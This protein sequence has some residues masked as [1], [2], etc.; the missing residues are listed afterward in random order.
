MPLAHYMI[1]KNIPRHMV[2]RAATSSMTL[3]PQQN[4]ADADGTLVV[5]GFAPPVGAFLQLKDSLERWR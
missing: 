4:A 5:V 1:V 3:L 2:A